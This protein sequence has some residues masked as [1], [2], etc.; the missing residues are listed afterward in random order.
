MRPPEFSGGN[1]S[2][3]RIE[4]AREASASMRP[5]EFSGGNAGQELVETLL[6]SLG[7]NEAAGILRRELDPADGEVKPIP[8]GLQ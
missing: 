1:A 3:D 4:A 6:P 7:F 2:E 5:P 8:N